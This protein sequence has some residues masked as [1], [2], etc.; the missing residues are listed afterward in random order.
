[1]ITPFATLQDIEE[2]YPAELITLAADE[3]TGIQDDTRIQRSLEDASSEVRGILKARYT[4]ADLA[5]ID[6]DSAQL[7]KL[8]T[9]DIALYLVALSFARS[10]E[11]IEDRYD[12]AIKRLEK[13]TDGKGGLSLQ[14][15]GQDS[16]TETDGGSVISPNEVI[17]DAP[18]RLFT[19]DKMG[20][21]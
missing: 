2:R 11:R 9:I 17:I 21:L 14:G 8:Y 19:R 15:G 3:E 16:G 18:E 13:M 12:R 7:L 6:E 5:Q 4:M 20:G 10:N 1:M